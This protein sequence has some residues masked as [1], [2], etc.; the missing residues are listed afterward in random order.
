MLLRLHFLDGTTSS[1]ICRLQRLRS[2][3]GPLAVLPVINLTEDEGVDFMEE[4]PRLGFYFYFLIFSYYV[5][6]F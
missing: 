1:L 3:N 4:D 6:Y 2:A 5:I